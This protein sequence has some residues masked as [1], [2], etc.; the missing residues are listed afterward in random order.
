MDVKDLT[1]EQIMDLAKWANFL[2]EEN[3]GLK[4]YILQLQAQ[5]QKA[6]GDRAVAE[7][8]LNNVVVKPITIE[9]HSELD[10]EYIKKK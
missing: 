4:S 10:E 9:I 2:N 1:E 8:H 5:L 3:K 7:H 6:R